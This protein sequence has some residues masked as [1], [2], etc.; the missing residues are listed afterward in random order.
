MQNQ[1]QTLNEF[2]E[3]KGVS[4]HLKVKRSLAQA[5]GLPMDNGTEEQQGALLRALKVGSMATVGKLTESFKVEGFNFEDKLTA[6]L[7]TQA[8]ASESQINMEKDGWRCRV[9]KTITISIVL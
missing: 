6:E 4:T 5:F 7:S 3:A 2:L 9:S 8:E 1:T